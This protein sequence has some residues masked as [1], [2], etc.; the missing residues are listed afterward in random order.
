MTWVLV[1][2]ALSGGTSASTQS[3]LANCEQMFRAAN[4]ADVKDA[5]CQSVTGDRVWI[6]KDGSYL[7]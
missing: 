1:I 4:L 3:S 7:R 5:Y 6:I 2:I